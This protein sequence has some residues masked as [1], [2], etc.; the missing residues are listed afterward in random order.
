[1]L[2]IQSIVSSLATLSQQ[3]KLLEGLKGL[4]VILGGFVL[5]VVILAIIIATLRKKWLDD[6]PLRIRTSTPNKSMRLTWIDGEQVLSV[7]FYASGR[8]KC[9]VVV[10]H[11]KL[12]NARAGE[13]MKKYWGEA[14]S[15][16]EA[17]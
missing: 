17:G 14:L 15:L 8:S 16:L 11:T 6:G 2:Q 5:L 7:H 3:G 9:Q 4:Y 12:P 1:M 13:R 10:Q